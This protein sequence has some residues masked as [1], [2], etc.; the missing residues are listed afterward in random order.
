MI[1]GPATK[2]L[3]AIAHILAMNGLPGQETTPR[4]N[5][6]NFLELLRGERTDYVLNNEALTYM[7]CAEVAEKVMVSS[8]SVD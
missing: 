1:L 2:G 5:R 3:I 4:K 6:I 8:E 7:A